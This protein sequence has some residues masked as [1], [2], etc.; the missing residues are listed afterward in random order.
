EMRIYREHEIGVMLDELGQ[1]ISDLQL[2]KP[3]TK[4]RPPQ[5]IEITEEE[6]GQ[7]IYDAIDWDGVRMC[8]MDVTKTAKAILSKLKG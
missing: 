7:I 2:G 4:P 1:F 8:G 5:G 6:I 3:L